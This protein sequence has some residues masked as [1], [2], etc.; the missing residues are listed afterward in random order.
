MRWLLLGP[1]VSTSCS[2]LAE[3][4]IRT[5][6]NWPHYGALLTAIIIHPAS[7]DIAKLF[8]FSYS[9]ADAAFHSFYKVPSL[10]TPAQPTPNLVFIYL[11]GLERTYFNEHIFPGLVTGLRE[12]EEQSLSFVNMGQTWG[13]NWTIAGVTA[14]QC[15]IPLVSGGNSMAGMDLFLPGALCLGDML[16]DE[17]YHLAFMGG[18]FLDFAGKGKF[19]SSHGFTEVLGKNVLLP[20]LA[21]PDYSSFWGLY[22]DS[23]LELAQEK[24]EALSAAGEKFGLFLLTLDT[25]HPKG[26]QSQSC[27]EQIYG[28]GTNSILNAVRCSDYLVTQFVSKI[29]AS[30]YAKNTVIVIA[31]DHLALPNTASRQLEKVDR[32]NLFIIIS[33]H[34]MHLG[35]NTKKGSTLDIGPT[36][37]SVLGYDI[38]AL[39]LGRNLFSNESTLVAAIEN[40]N[41]TLK[42]WRGQLTGLW[43]FP[44]LPEK[45]TIDPINDLLRF[46]DRIVKI[47]VLFELT[48]DMRTIDI[49]F[50]F[51]GAENLSHHLYTT[52]KKTPFLWVDTCKR[53]YA[54]DTRL[55]SKG[56]CV[57]AGTLGNQE[58]ISRTVDEEIQLSIIEAMKRSYTMP[59]MD[60]LYK[61]RK[62]Y[63]KVD[64]TKSN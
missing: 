42:E 61:N 11:E 3:K 54:L 23:L 44:D 17:G 6:K 30:E 18:A 64:R 25:H 49:K 8:S 21:D 2:N 56:I 1:L 52:G 16:N 45:I 4:K 60:T 26:H 55:G 29:L 53:I 33:P 10:Q 12:I 20:H 5:K 34:K 48:E 59:V 32:K 19:Y 38:T 40:P 51:Y 22:D 47:P 46:N 37:L 9:P 13:A 62:L 35:K 27:S 39:G 63:L 15:G 7:V 14:S 50:P 43:E 28:D 41:T 24:F 57:Y 36:L 58:G 31:S